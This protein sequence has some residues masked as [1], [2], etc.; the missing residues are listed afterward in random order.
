MKKTGKRVMIFLFTQLILLGF[1]QWTK[2]LAILHLKDQESISLIS[3]IFQ[4]H[5]LEN[6][7]AAFGM[8]SGMQWIFVFIALAV[9][10]LVAYVYFKIPWDK[11]YGYL[12]ITGL[13][14]SSGAIGNVLDRI[15]RNYVVDFFYFELIDFP[16]FNVADIY[17]TVGTIVLAILILFYYQEEELEGILGSSKGKR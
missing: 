4:L 14:I 17:I 9:M 8:L 2:Y 13:F 1:D 12:R 6:T 10:I 11:K 16:V 3:G 5:Y 7:G 15:F